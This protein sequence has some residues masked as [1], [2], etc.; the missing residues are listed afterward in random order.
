LP[1]QPL[2][3]KLGR[4]TPVIRSHKR[5]LVQGWLGKVRLVHTATGQTKAK[6]GGSEPTFGVQLESAGHHHLTR[7]S[8]MTWKLG[9]F[10]NLSIV[11]SR[12]PEF[13]P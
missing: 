5:R 2:R 3:A 10:Y 7:N 1:F 9:Y 4:R 13:T 6:Q 8:K 12:S 11:I